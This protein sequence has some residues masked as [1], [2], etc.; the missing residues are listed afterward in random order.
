MALVMAKENQTKAF[1]RRNLREPVL[2]TKEKKSYQI[3]IIFVRYKIKKSYAKALKSAKSRIINFL[4]LSIFVAKYLFNSKFLWGNQIT[5]LPEAV[6]S[7][8]TNLQ[9][10]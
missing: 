5:Q 6:F 4:E 2:N 3:I 1:P 8:L 10:L 9:D 7:G